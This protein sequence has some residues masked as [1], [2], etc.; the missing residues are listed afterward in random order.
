MTAVPAGSTLRLRGE[1]DML[2][3][4]SVGAE[5]RRLL[6][7]AEPGVPLVVDLG[8]VTFLDSAGLSALVQLRLD[9]TARGVEVVL[10]VVPDRVSALLRVSGLTDLFATD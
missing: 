7:G 8:E 10:H 9:A 5:G 2:T 6:A 4:D 3:A 1:I